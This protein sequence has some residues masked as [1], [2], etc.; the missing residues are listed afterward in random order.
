MGTLPRQDGKQRRDVARFDPL[1]TLELDAAYDA[2][3]AYAKRMHDWPGLRDAIKA[4]L[5]EQ[6]NFVAWWALNIAVQRGGDR[7]SK[8]SATIGALG[9]KEAEASTGISH[10]QVSKWRRR[11]KEPDKYEA[12]LYGT[13]YAKA[14]AE[15]VTTTAAQWTGDPESYTPTQYIEAARAVMGGIDLDPASNSIAQQVVRADAFFDEQTDGLKQ[16]WRGR[17]FLNPPYKYPLVAKF[18]TKLLEELVATRVTAAILLTNNNTDTRWWH[19]AARIADGVCLTLGRINFY[20]ASG[21][22]TQPTNGQ[23]FFYFGDDGAAFASV[24]D[25]FGLIMQVRA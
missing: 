2:A 8:S 4:K 20:K 24:F 6:E 15:A 3:I 16:Q 22:I 18:I 21:E 13:A 1:Q 17:V 25:R 19:E 23:S 5:E 11:L 9:F 10:Q 14:M 7:R 12:M